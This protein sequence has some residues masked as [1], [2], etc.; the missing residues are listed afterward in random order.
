MYPFSVVSKG[1]ELHMLVIM[2]IILRDFFQ[3]F[4]FLEETNS[5]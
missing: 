2:E 5:V 4:V 3:S 1:E